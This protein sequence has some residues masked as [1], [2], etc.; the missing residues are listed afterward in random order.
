MIKSSNAGEFFLTELIMSIVK[1]YTKTGDKGET[2]LYGGKRVSKADLRVEAYGAIDELSS[3][4]GVV[5]A[6][7]QKAKIKMRNYMV[8]IKNELERMPHDLYEIAALL[9]TPHDTQ[10]AKGQVI[11]KKL[12]QHLQE[13][14]KE[15]EQYIDALTEK[16]PPLHAFILPGGGRVGSLL[17]QARTICRRAE[18]RIVALARKDDIPSEILIYMNRLSDLL[19]MVA[20]FVNHKEKH[21]EILWNKYQEF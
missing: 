6:E 12:P 4:I 1:I 18:R 8:K 5:L 14:T 19:F 17:H 10:V 7:M 13:R 15:I 11:H 20:R 2:S 16:L 3:A 21:K 9:A